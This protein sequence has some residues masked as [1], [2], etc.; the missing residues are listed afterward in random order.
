MNSHEPHRYGGLLGVAGGILSLGGVAL[1]AVTGFMAPAD[2]IATAAVD[3][4]G[5]ILAGAQ[6]GV[7]GVLL[8]A[9]FGAVLQRRILAA[10]P[11]TPLASAALVGFAGTAISALVGFAG[12]AAL[13]LRAEEDGSVVAGSAAPLADLADLCLGGLAPAAL[14]LA[15]AA[16]SIAAIRSGAIVPKWLAYL[17]LP[18]ALGLV[19]LPINWA[20]GPIGVLWTIAAG[21]SL[22]WNPQRAVV[23]E[24]VM[25]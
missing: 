6:L 20:V 4:T 9:A 18:V 8:L 21:V 13:A 19:V 11:G 24:P 3:D 2:E 10:D 16:V 23:A 12:W 25:A 7:I 14:G 15:V 22:S 5:R 17:G 1:V